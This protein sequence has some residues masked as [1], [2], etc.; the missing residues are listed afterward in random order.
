MRA[1]SGHEATD[2]RQV[3]HVVRDLA[4][5]DDA[6]LRLLLGTDAVTMS[7]QA[8]QELAANDDHWRQVTLSVSDSTR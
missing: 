1:G 2:A 4:G 5:R 6:P 3:A 8:A 7:Q